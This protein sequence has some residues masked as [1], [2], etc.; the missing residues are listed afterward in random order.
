MVFGAAL[1]SNCGG[2][3][4]LVICSGVRLKPGGGVSV[5]WRTL[6]GCSSRRFE[7][8]G[9]YWRVTRR[10]WLACDQRRLACA[11]GKRFFVCFGLQG[12][13]LGSDIKSAH[14]FLFCFVFLLVRRDSCTRGRCGVM[15][16]L[17]FCRIY[18]C[19][20]KL[21]GQFSPLLPF[22]VLGLWDAA[23][24]SLFEGIY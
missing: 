11:R 19:A 16:T 12:L 22:G 13:P 7:T 15:K 24:G 20:R 23:K 14:V 5:W 10:V 21:R 18:Q 3:G 6:A 17:F 8:A 4:C 9:P 1:A 2:L